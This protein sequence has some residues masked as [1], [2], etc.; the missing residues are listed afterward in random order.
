ME[1]NKEGKRLNKNETK[2]M[3]NEIARERQKGRIV[4]DGEW[5]EE[6]TE[7]KYMY[8]GT[9]VTFENESNKDIDSR[10]TAS[11]KR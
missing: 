2:I 5:L 8:L 10:I 1:G 9:I 4:I 11:L 6:V 3:Y 7:Y